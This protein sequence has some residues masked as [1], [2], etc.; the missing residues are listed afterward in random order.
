[1]LRKF[2]LGVAAV[3]H[4]K[5]YACAAILLA[6]SLSAS[7]ARLVKDELGRSVSLPDRVHRVICLTP[8]VT[9]TVYAIGGGADIAGITDY[10]H[11]PPQAEREKPSVGDILHPSLEKIAA[12]HPD[13]AIAVAT[14][15]S[16]ETVQAIER[17]GIPVFLVTDSGLTALYRSISS[18]G[19]A[20]G[21][22]HEAALLVAQLRTRE[23][24]VRARAAQAGRGPSVF[25]VLS[26]DP[27]ITAGRGAFITELISAAGARSITRDLPQ[28]WLRVSLE[29]MISRRPDYMLVFEDSPFGLAEMRQRPGWNAFA[30]VRRGRVLRI[31]DRLQFPSP[32]AFDALEDF[33]R[34][35][36]ALPIASLSARGEGP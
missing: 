27:C 36:H 28:D 23:R 10:T 29:T 31:D 14:L 24:R 33:A 15:N 26:L 30:A 13:L 16:A 25:L 5:A 21:R 22:E 2:Q 12:L 17:L 8:S 18:I 20:L 19:L 32:V 11:Y 9:D 3:A 1:V 35:I 4:E 6:F 34:E 7:A